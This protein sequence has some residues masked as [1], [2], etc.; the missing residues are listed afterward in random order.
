MGGVEGTVN[1]EGVETMRKWYAIIPMLLMSVIF[2]GCSGD[3]DAEDDGAAE[4][5]AMV[6]SDGDAGHSEESGGHDDD[7]DAGHAEE[8]GGHDDDHAAVATVADLGE[9]LASLDG[10]AA[11]EVACGSCIYGMDGIEECVLAAKV[12]DKEYLVT[13]IE[14]DTHGA[15]LC[16]ES[17]TARTANI[18]GMVHEHGIVAT[19]VKLTD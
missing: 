16:M 11:V 14:F 7:G 15:G 17:E 3:D 9:M 2:A 8:S 13:G 19:S 18:V 4:E 5:A 12:K 6:E 10:S 1:F